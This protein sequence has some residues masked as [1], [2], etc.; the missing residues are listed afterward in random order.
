MKKKM[1]LAKKMLIAMVLGL[2]AG[3]GF[4]MLREQLVASGQN[5]LWN[6]I[7]SWLFADITAAGNEKA[8]GLFYVV[9]QIFVRLMQV[10]IVP[11][12]FCSITLAIAKMNDARKLGRIAGKT[13]GCFAFEYALAV[14]LA[15]LAGFA[16]YQA[17]GFSAVSLS[18]LEATTGTT[19]ANPL[20]VLLDAFPLNFTAVLSSNSSV[21]AVVV[22]AVG[23]GLGINACNGKITILKNL[24]EEISELI[25]VI[26][27][28][29][30]N[31]LAPIGVFALLTRTFAAYGV[32]YLLPAV[33]YVVTTVVLLVIFLLAG[34]ALII[35]FVGRM[36]PLPFVKKITKVA[37]FGFSTSSSA[38]TLP[39]NQQTTVEEL[40]ADE[41]ISSFVLP[42]GM[43]VNMN[44]TAIMQVVATIFIAAVGGYPLS[45]SMIFTISLLAIVASIGT[46]AAPGAGAVILFTV[47]TGIG[48]GNDAALMAYSLILA[49]NRPIE[50]LCTS[51]NVVG[52]SCTAL[53]V[54][55]SEGSLDMEKYNAKAK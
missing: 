10:V 44:G 42:L 41:E 34:Y 37:I 26:L 4:L 35:L 21:L 29:I 43:T 3:I 39:L 18:N 7:N 17:G 38:A 32:E 15:G 27:T 23:V 31:H 12:V 19:G 20:V 25:T 24:C 47:L 22:C 45:L 1:S 2:S 14:L 55:K 46:P 6:T 33:T 51:L 30:V 48:F 16:I 28:F 36:N 52:D 54:A 13:V 9:G 53:L 8:I 5:E 49:I 11:M 40:G 50:M